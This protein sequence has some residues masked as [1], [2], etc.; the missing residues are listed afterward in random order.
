MI[1]YPS[2]NSSAVLVG[3][4]F[5]DSPFP[6]FIPAP[7]PPISPKSPAHSAHSPHSA[8]NSP[9]GQKTISVPSY[10]DPSISR[11]G[12]SISPHRRSNP[13]SPLVEQPI[14]QHRQH[15]PYHFMLAPSGYPE[16]GQDETAFN[17]YASS[18][19]N[20]PFS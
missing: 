5:F 20:P 19:Q 18:S 11:Q 15:D 3:A 17:N 4:L 1:I 12:Q 8:V 14:A 9:Y 6:N 7:P 10:D 2:S 13:N 16:I